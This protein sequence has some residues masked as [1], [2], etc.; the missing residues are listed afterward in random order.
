MNP[1]D[2]HLEDEFDMRAEF[3]SEHEDFLEY[4]DDFIG[5]DIYNDHGEDF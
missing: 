3:E 4:P 1:E 2:A 5:P